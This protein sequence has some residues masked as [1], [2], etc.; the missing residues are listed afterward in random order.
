LTTSFANFRECIVQHF[1]ILRIQNVPASSGD[2]NNFKYSLLCYFDELST[3]RLSSPSV[4]SHKLREH[5]FAR[6]DSRG[7]CRLAVWPTELRFALLSVG[8]TVKAAALRSVPAADRLRINKTGTSRAG[9]NPHSK[10]VGGT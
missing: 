4:F 10:L 3:V 6:N 2:S 9:V 7:F 5:E 8:A 1:G